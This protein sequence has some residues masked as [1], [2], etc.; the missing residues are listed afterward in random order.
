MGAPRAATAS[1]VAADAL[2]G[3]PTYDYVCDACGHAFEH[4][5]GI[6]EPLLLK[7][8]ECS[9]RKLRRLIG[10]GAGVVFKGSGFYET[11]YKR[12]APAGKSEPA[13]AGKDA[14]KDAASG[15]DG[16]EGAA[17]DS[18]KAGKT[19]SKDSGSDA[20]TS[21]KDDAART[22]GS[23]EQRSGKGGGD[24][25]AAPPASSR[26]KSSGPA[27][28]A[29]PPSGPAAGKPAEPPAA[30]RRDEDRPPRKNGGDRGRKSS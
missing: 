3:M 21:A 28:S 12:A 18:D 8:P 5:Q 2:A 7:C 23:R 17:T 10:T 25:D 24:A 19:A 15:R 27:A 13:A 11:D 22:A 4:F 26:S 16:G 9:R 20:A 6:N 29:R 1:R 30:P 14:G